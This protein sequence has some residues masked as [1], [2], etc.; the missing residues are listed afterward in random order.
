[1]SPV[2]W[3]IVRD[4]VVADAPPRLRGGVRLN[5][6]HV[7]EVVPPLTDHVL[8]QT[9]IFSIIPRAPDPVLA[10]IGLAGLLPRPLRA[11]ILDVAPATAQALE[12][13]ARIIDERASGDCG[14]DAGQSGSGRHGAGMGGSTATNRSEGSAHGGRLVVEM[15]KLRARIF[16][17]VEV[18]MC[19]PGP[20]SAVKGHCVCG[21]T[22]EANAN[23]YTTAT[24]AVM[25][26]VLRFPGAVL[27]RVTSD[28]LFRRDVDAATG[29]LSL[30]HI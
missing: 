13:Q 19:V 24:A 21:D 23:I 28:V 12:Q 26:L 1:M 2:A 7:H 4:H 29:G 27:S 15:P 17:A 14:S 30:I 20:S 3:R 22:T 11:A 6:L 18:V 9:S 25:D 5:R 10:L 8:A 16:D